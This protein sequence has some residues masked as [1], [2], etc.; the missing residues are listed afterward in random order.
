[1]ATIEQYDTPESYLEAVNKRIESKE[2]FIAYMTGK[3]I[4]G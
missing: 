3:V 4:E 2:R 1:M